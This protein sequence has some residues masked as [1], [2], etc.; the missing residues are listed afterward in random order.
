MLREDNVTLQ[1]SDVQ[2]GDRVLTVNKDGSVAFSDVYYKRNRLASPDT[3]E[4]VV[5]IRLGSGEKLSLTPNHLVYVKERN[6]PRVYAT[7]PIPAGEVVV[8][9][10]L[11]TA[12]P[13]I[14]SSAVSSPVVS[15][16]RAKATVGFHSLY[17]LQGAV[18]VDGVLAS[19][20]D[21]KQGEWYGFAD[22][23]EER[24]MYIFAPT[25]ARTRMFQAYSDAW[26]S[27]RF[28]VWLDWAGW[29][30]GFS[31]TAWA[32]FRWATGSSKST[33]YYKMES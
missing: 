31:F 13:I 6:D 17:T 11:W 26:E 2:L 8:G 18:V 22:N 21:D 28:P 32:L 9:N 10:E 7:R 3:E 20:Y 23:I 33:K 24:L 16:K 30:A 15:V 29:S 27:M 4:E 5:E 25:F 12:Q 14:S 19:S 1:L